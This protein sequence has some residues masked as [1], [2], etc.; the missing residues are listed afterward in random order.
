MP[1]L[2]PRR[3][4]FDEAIGAFE[5]T[6]PLAVG[7][8]GG[9]DSTA[10]LVACAHRW[11]GRVRAFHVNHGLQAAADNFERHCAAVAARLDVPFSSQRVDA[12]HAAGKSPE[13]TARNARYEAFRA[14]ALMEPTYPA[15]KS[16]ALGHHAD[17]QV[18]TLLL[19][20]SRGS[21]LPGLSS[22]PK[23]AS[24]GE[25]TFYRPLL[26]VPSAEI[27]AWLSTRG[28]SWLEDPTN[29]DTRYTRNR[30]RTVLLPAL[31]QSFAQFRATFARSAAHAA[32]AQ[33]LLNEVAEQ[34]LAQMGGRP[35]ITALQPLSVARQANVLRHWLATTHGGAPSAA[36]LDQ[37]RSQVTA[38]RTRGHG[39]HL[40]VGGGFVERQGDFLDWYNSAPSP[41]ASR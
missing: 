41:D 18:E 31:E 27:R 14:M 23:E 30:I 40:K 26:A 20:L 19:A 38:C 6:L 34:D 25:L 35:R 37:L 24:R 17:D 15:I 32:Q 9:A 7:F 10:L 33:Q 11:P 5:P 28:L 8:S 1:T 13:A 21:G 3:S 12:R 2:S 16:I 4:A 22:M 36:Q 39:I 29:T